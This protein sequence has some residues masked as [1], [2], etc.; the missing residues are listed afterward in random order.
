[1]P[2]THQVEAIPIAFSVTFMDAYIML[3]KC[4]G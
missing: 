4:P 1:M 3:V 2:L